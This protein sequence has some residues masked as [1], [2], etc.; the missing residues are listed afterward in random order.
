MGLGS[1]KASRHETA[2]VSKAAGVTSSDYW[3][4]KPGSA[5]MTVD[6]LPGTVTAVHDGPSAGNEAYQV[7]LDKGMGGG[8][9]TASQLSPTGTTTASVEHTAADDYPELGS[10]L[11]DRPDPAIN[12]V[13]GSRTAS[14]ASGFREAPITSYASLR[15]TETSLS[16]PDTAECEDCG[17]T[18]PVDEMRTLGGDRQ[19]ENGPVAFPSQCEDCSKKQ[20]QD[21]A[22]RYAPRHAVNDA[23]MSQYSSEV[24]NQ[25]DPGEAPAD[26]QCNS[27][28]GDFNY[29][30]HGACPHCGEKDIH[31]F[32]DHEPRD[33]QDDYYD[34]PDSAM[35]SGD[36]YDRHADAM[37]RRRTYSLA[38][39]PP[40]SRT[41]EVEGDEDEDLDHDPEGPDP[42]DAR[43]EVGTNRWGNETAYHAHHGRAYLG[44]FPDEAQARAALWDHEDEHPGYHPNHWVDGHLD[45]SNDRQEY[46]K[47]PHGWMMRN[48]PD[49]EHAQQRDVG[50]TV[51]DALGD[52]EHLKGLLGDNK[53]GPTKWSSKTADHGDHRDLQVGPTDDSDGKEYSHGHD[54]WKGE[55][56]TYEPGLGCPHCKDGFMTEDARS[57][58][59][60]EQHPGEYSGPTDDLMMAKDRINEIR[61]QASKTAASGPCNCGGGGHSGDEHYEWAQARHAEGTHDAWGR[62]LHQAFDGHGA[63]DCNNYDC[64]EHPQS[65]Y[66]QKP[67]EMP[68]WLANDV[69]S[70]EEKNL[71]KQVND[72]TSGSEWLLDQQHEGPTKYSSQGTPGPY[73]STCVHC[74]EPLRKHLYD[75][76]VWVNRKNE[77]GKDGHLHEPQRGFYDAAE[78]IEDAFAGTPHH[79]YDELAENRIGPSKYSSLDPYSLIREAAADPEFRFEFTGSWSD[80]RNKAKRIRTEGGVRIVVASSQGIQAEVKGDHHIY[81]TGLQYAPGSRKIAIWQCGCKWA[82]YAWGRS[83]RYKRFEGR[84]CSHALAVQFEASSRG[85]F[86]REVSQGDGL[87]P[88]QKK[89]TPVVIQFDKDDD[90][91]LTRR[92]V[93]PGN[94]RTVWSKVIEPAPVI[95]T[96][97]QMATSGDDADEIGILLEASSI[98]STAL[99]RFAKMAAVNDAWGEPA[100]PQ[101]TW[102]TLPGATKQK[103]PME[104]PAS[105]G[106]AAGPDPIGWH[107]ISPMTMGDRVASHYS[108]QAYEGDSDVCANCGKSIRRTTMDPNVPWVHHH[109]GNSKCDVSSPADAVMLQ[110]VDSGEAAPTMHTPENELSPTHWCHFCGMGVTPDSKGNCPGCN[111]DDDLSPM[112]GQHES[113]LDD[114]TA[115]WD[116]GDQNEYGVQADLHDEPEPALPSTDGSAISDGLLG[117]QSSQGHAVYDDVLSPESESIMS[118]GSVESIVAEFQRTAGA[119]VI[120]KDSGRGGPGPSDSDIAAAARAHLEGKTAMRA[121]S[122]EEQ[123]R[124]IDEPGRAGNTDV[125]DIADTHYAALDAIRGDDDDDEDWMG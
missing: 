7:T 41:A 56:F 67:G 75:E 28:G 83:P 76:G 51:D 6:G 77:S 124:L 84:M 11:Q 94:M 35:D 18:K 33:D 20:Y 16:E 54:T 71:R 92:T 90:K 99:V 103:D 97:A 121:F 13:L 10:I 55:S 106:F 117:D 39:P 50:E 123:R 102:P 112:G 62:P 70:P 43:V 45:T 91:N 81:E 23:E 80:V 31:Q 100:P 5:V 86:G 105:A 2:A 59:I 3:E 74:G 79:V 26:T 66:E 52:S 61:G 53:I 38:E 63:W 111:S 82:A 37:D 60:R 19:T 57:R 48:S 73:D 85:M 21:A 44:H 25:R 119:Q 32:T 116:S 15:Q 24:A 122:P 109:S 108:E 46:D 93:P 40:F 87:L 114:G 17:K 125:L 78:K 89:R 110:G 47:D 49:Y 1:R 68:G 96:V 95:T 27:C 104:N 34:D 29:D 98:R 107:S 8:L 58:H 118:T 9:Y 101:Q 36:P 22:R 120:M 115:T 12:T 30:A 64:T 113:S 88:G 72:A 4:F 69:A 14:S 42:D 65:M